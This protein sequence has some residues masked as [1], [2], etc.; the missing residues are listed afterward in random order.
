MAEPPLN[1]FPKINA[2]LFL[3]DAPP[4]S[5]RSFQA[6]FLGFCPCLGYFP[7]YIML[8]RSMFTAPSS[9]SLLLSLR[10]FTLCQGRNNKDKLNWILGVSVVLPE[11]ADVFLIS[12]FFSFP[13]HQSDILL[14]P[15]W[16]WSCPRFLPVKGCFSLP[17]MLNWGSGPGLL[18]HQQSILIVV[19]IVITAK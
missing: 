3:L 13:T 11:S 1:Q 16:V 2:S 6:S 18:R 7:K 8:S 9:Y 17:L 15:L 4:P 12:F 19:V 5:S 10:Y 14:P